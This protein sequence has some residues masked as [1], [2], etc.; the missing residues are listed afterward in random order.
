M[1]FSIFHEDKTDIYCLCV[2]N[3]AMQIF[4][5][6]VDQTIYKRLVTRFRELVSDTDLLLA[7]VIRITAS[8]IPM[9]EI[10]KRIGPNNM[11]AS[12]NTSLTYDDEQLK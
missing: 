5:H 9:V 2:K 7:K 1:L 8:G 11:L 12:I 3:Q 10:F 4:L 6:N